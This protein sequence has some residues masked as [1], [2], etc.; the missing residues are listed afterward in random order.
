MWVQ[1]LH[2]EHLQRGS[3]SGWHV[4]AFVTGLVEELQCVAL[5]KLTRVLATVSV[6]KGDKRLRR[7]DPLLANR[8]DAAAATWIFP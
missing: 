3:K 5:A 8:G 1:G 7:A 2:V 4:Q 6:E